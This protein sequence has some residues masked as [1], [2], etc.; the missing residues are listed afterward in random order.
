MSKE[1]WSPLHGIICMWA[2][3]PQDLPDGWAICDGTNGTPDLRGRYPYGVTV[4][5]PVG[6]KFGYGTHKHNLTTNSSTDSL[7]AGDAILTGPPNG[8]FMDWT[9]GHTHTAETDTQPHLP[10]SYAI[11]YIMKL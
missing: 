4:S 5:R 8:Y 1:G 10:Y 6:S 9:Q 11:Y 7:Q 2:G 3:Q